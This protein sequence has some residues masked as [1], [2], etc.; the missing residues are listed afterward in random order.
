MASPLSPARRRNAGRRDP[1]RPPRRRRCG[2]QPAAGLGR[3]RRHLRARPPNSSP[4]ARTT[5]RCSPRGSTGRAR[6]SHDPAGA[7]PAAADLAPA[8]AALA[9]ARDQVRAVAVGAFTGDRLGPWRRCWPARPQ[10]TCSTASACSDHRRVQRRGPGHAGTRPRRR[11]GDGGGRGHGRRGRG[12]G[13]PPG[14]RNRPTSTGRSRPSRPSTTG[15]APRRTAPRGGRRAAR[16]GAGR[17]PARGSRAA[18]EQAAAPADAAASSPPR[19]PRRPAPPQRR[20]AA[21]AAAGAVPPRS[22]VSTPWRSWATRTCGRPQA[23][24]PSTARA[25]SSTRTP[26]RASSCRTRRACSRRWALRCPVRRSSP[27]TW[28]SSTARSATW[29]STSATANG[30][31]LHVR[32]SR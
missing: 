11:A 7:E 27:V 20:S 6:S 14:R 32:P 3:P 22:A 19:R 24:T 17:R 10:T 26:L 29:A 15:S 31:R 25:W 5:S 2:A 18:A 12:A 13:R 21:P 4:P 30:A 9:Q 28:C 16:G 8:E 1:G 23:P